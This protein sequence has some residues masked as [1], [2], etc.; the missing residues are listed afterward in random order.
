MMKERDLRNARCL[1]LRKLLTEYLIILSIILDIMGVWLISCKLATSVKYPCFCSGNMD[2]LFQLNGSRLES[3]KVV[4]R[5]R[6]I[7]G[8]SLLIHGTAKGGRQPRPKRSEIF[9]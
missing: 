4:K 8:R 1:A 9:Y 3:M 6:G 2:N 7:N 5:L